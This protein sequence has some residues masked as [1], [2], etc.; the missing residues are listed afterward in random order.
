[1]K[2]LG[3]PRYYLGLEIEHC[4]DRILV[5][6]SNYTQ[7]VLQR[8]NEDKAKPSSTPMV[9]RTLDNKRDPFH[10]K[11]DEEEILEPKV[12]YLSA[13]GALLYLAQCIRPN[14]SF[15]VNFL[16]R[17]S[18]VPT[19]R[20]WNGVKNIFRY[21]NGT[22]D[23]GLFY[24][25]ES[26]SVASPYGSRIDS[27]LVGYAYARYLFDPYRA[28]SQTDYVFTIGD[29]AISWRSTKQKLVTTS[30][31][32]AKI[33]ALHEASSECFWLRVVMEHI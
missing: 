22:M 14:I 24:T 27:C 25:H 13:I 10:P 6:Q 1:M 16:A 5:H 12:P 9:V 4:S 31:N 33:L 8:F 28:L 11:V 29:T 30:S 2:D 32:H 23:L 26:S 17:Y 18:N 7:K 3:K 15:N 21:L 19:Y 20:H